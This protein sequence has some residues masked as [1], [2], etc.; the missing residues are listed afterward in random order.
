[1]F[2][3]D[4]LMAVDQQI[5]VTSQLVDNAKNTNER[6]E[7]TKNL[8]GLFGSQ[9]ENYYSLFYRSFNF[10]HLTHAECYFQAA[11]DALTTIDQQ[12]SIYL[13]LSLLAMQEEK[14]FYQDSASKLYIEAIAEYRVKERVPEQEARHQ[15]NPAS[16]HPIFEQE[17]VKR[18]R[19]MPVVA[20]SMELETVEPTIKLGF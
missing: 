2:V 14:L 1:M 9:A 11:I 7:Q 5:R 19:Y 3:R 18:V 16:D 20:D 17:Q 10:L 8:S 13:Q 12:P 15:N 6:V 4:R